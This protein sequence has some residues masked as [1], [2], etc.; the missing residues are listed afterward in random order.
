MDGTRTQLEYGRV[1]RYKPSKYDRT[2][3]LAVLVPPGAND[4][5]PPPGFGWGLGL[6]ILPHVFNEKGNAVV[7][8]LV[9]YCGSSTS[10]RPARERFGYA[11]DEIWN[12][13][14][15]EIMEMRRRDASGEFN[16]IHSGRQL[17]EY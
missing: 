5:D 14:S 2:Q 16:P 8:E 7:R 15:E 12:M 10:I 1:F 4:Y 9:H 13:T 11:A 3:V 6:T 17:T